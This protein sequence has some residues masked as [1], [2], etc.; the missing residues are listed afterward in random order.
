MARA[1]RYADYREPPPGFPVECDGPITHVLHT[2]VGPIYYCR[3]HGEAHASF[4]PFAGY[5]RLR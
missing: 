5:Q 3:I 1:C 2:A 4:N